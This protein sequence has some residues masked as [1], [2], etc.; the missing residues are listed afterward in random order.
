MRKH[1]ESGLLAAAP[2]FHGVFDLAR[3][4][5]SCELVVDPSNLRT[6]NTGKH[7][8]RSRG[9]PHRS[10]HTN[11]YPVVRRVRL[12]LQR[13]AP[14]GRAVAYFRARSQPRD[15]ERDKTRGRNVVGESRKSNGYI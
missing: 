9:G 14:Q 15:K 8:R 11:P 1:S 7:C 5:F 12:H 6:T 10:L 4:S 2:S 3:V 13:A